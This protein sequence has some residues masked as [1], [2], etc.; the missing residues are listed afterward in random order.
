[1]LD[2][3]LIEKLEKWVK[4]HPE[5][6]NEPFINMSTGDEY[7]LATIAMMLRASAEGEAQLSESLEPQ[8]A[9]LEVW[10]GGL[11]NG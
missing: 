2:N 3:S 6:A 5:A 1:M 11:E 9:D 10:V 8:L 4:A 7:T